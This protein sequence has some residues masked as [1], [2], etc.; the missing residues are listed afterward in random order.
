MNNLQGILM[1]E[2][3]KEGKLLACQFQKEN[4][5]HYEENEFVPRYSSPDARTKARYA[6]EFYPSGNLKSIYLE[7][8][9]FI[10]TSIGQLQ[11]EFVTF[12]ETGELLRVFPVYGQI[13][14][15]WSEKEEKELL[16]EIHV[17]INGHDYHGKFSCICFYPSG[18]VKSL[19][20]WPDEFIEVETNYGPVKVRY[21][22][23]FYESGTI[24]SLEPAIPIVIPHAN[25]SFIAYNQ[26]AVGVSGDFNSLCFHTNGEVES[27]YSSLTGLE[28]KD[29]RTNEVT[30]L[31]PKIVPSP[32][33]P[34]K[35]TVL[36]V[37]Y[38]FGEES[39][40]ITDSA[41]SSITYSNLEYE[42]NAIQIVEN[43]PYVGCCGCSECS[44]C[45]TCR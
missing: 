24:R 31:A 39:I 35:K 20:I 28:V 19:T 26:Q 42:W 40:Q 29:R 34:T 3:S 10:K 2:Y 23:C 11:A 4:V 1:P 22:I 38:R 16:P 7:K 36:P 44:D 45:N 37:K 21:G 9:T 5:I 12:Y 33:D 8:A 41:G 43:L 15:F 6:M 27:L 25:G 17:S 32:M 14:G 30:K 18:A 13:S